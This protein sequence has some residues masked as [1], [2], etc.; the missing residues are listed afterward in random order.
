MKLQPDKQRRRLLTLLLSLCLVAPV[1]ADKAAQEAAHLQ[2]FF[3]TGELLDYAQ[4][5]GSARA[6]LMAAE[7]MLEHPVGVLEEP[8]REL[9]QEGSSRILAPRARPTPADLIRQAQTLS[10]GKPGMREWAQELTKRAGDSVR[11]A[12]VDFT[13]ASFELAPKTSHQLN[14]QFQLGRLSRVVARSSH[15]DLLLKVIDRSGA[16]LAQGRGQVSFRTPRQQRLKVVLENPSEQAVRYEL[17][18]R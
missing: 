3:L 16:T 12:A 18:I 10:A 14:P 13:T 9:G 1:S 6:Y 11:V 5:V 2:A 8:V 7:L 15:T 4:R 17:L